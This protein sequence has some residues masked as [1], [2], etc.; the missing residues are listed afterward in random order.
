MTGPGTGRGVGVPA[1]RAW[2]MALAALVTVT[3]GLLAMRAHLDKTHVALA[4][5]LVVLGAS[6]LGGRL[7]GL[8]AAAAGFLVFNYFFLPPYYTLVIADPLDWFVLVAFL[9][10]GIVAAQL[11]ARAQTEA[12]EARRNAEQ[13]V[14]LGEQARQAEALREADRL[15][16]ALLATVSHDLRTPL[17]TIRALAQDIAAEGDERAVTIAEEVD[18]L[19]RFVADLLDLSQ[20]KAG[21]LPQAIAINAAED[22]MGAALQRVGGLARGRDLR[23]SLDPSDPVLVGRFDFAHSLRILANLLENALKYSPPEAP[24]EFT[25]RRDGAWLRFDVADRGPGIAPEL[26][27]R[28]FEPFLRGGDQRGVGGAGLGLAIAR[29]LAEAQGGR[30]SCEPRAGGGTV[31]TL[32]LPAADVTEVAL[33][34]VT[35]R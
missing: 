2:G 6:A 12:A 14:R 34:A 9:L 20:L 7:L 18:R 13:V 32:R 22:L 19:N 27:S 33:E 29:G 24:I 25:V 35:A 15:K 28:I 11:L 31:F 17:T 4:L 16:D 1:G 3:A 23:A 5:L 26:T 30:L 8:V 10:T 21:A